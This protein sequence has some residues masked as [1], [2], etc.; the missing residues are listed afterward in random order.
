MMTRNRHVNFWR[1]VLRAVPLA[2]TLLW[3]T[4]V[5]GD[6]ARWGID[7]LMEA[8]R[9]V[10]S[11]HAT[12]TERKS[13]AMLEEPVDSSGELFYTAPDRMEKRTLK[14]KPESMI[15]DRDTLVMQRGKKKRRLRLQDAPELV[16]FI[17]SIRGILAGDREALERHYRL[18]LEGTADDWTLQMVPS[19]DKVLRVVSQ[20]RIAGAGNAVRSIETLQAD[21]DSS[22][23]LIERIAVP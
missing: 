9:Q 21:G 5:S 23:M 19:D 1:R 13:I 2:L 10:R 7:Q 8:M 6:D 11:D 3:A 16:A 4:I 14:P 18:T 15:L 22:L 17:D 12:F 20:I